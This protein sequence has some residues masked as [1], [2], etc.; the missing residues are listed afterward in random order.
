MS[1]LAFTSSM[2]DRF[3]EHLHTNFLIQQLIWVNCVKYKWDSQ[4]SAFY[5]QKKIRVCNSPRPQFNLMNQN[6]S[7]TTKKALLGWK[8][9]QTVRVSPVIYKS[10]QFWLQL[11]LKQQW[12]GWPSPLDSVVFWWLGGV[13]G[14]EWQRCCKRIVIGWRLIIC[15]NLCSEKA[16]AISMYLGSTL[17]V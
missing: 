3:F 8:P 9:D 16:A 6:K 2:D 15:Q 14:I 10:S 4:S 17:G 1:S 12:K 13:N 5:Q 7:C 11:H